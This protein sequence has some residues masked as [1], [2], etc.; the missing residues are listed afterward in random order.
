MKSASELAA[1]FPNPLAVLFN[2]CFKAGQELQIAFL[3]PPRNLYSPGSFRK[4]TCGSHA[5]LEKLFVH[6]T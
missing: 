1:I 5:A 2:S 6:C 4:A 3:K